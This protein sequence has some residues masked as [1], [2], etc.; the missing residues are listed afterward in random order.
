MKTEFFAIKHIA[1][2]SSTLDFINTGGT[3]YRVWLNSH[4]FLTL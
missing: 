4:N 1:K 3:A 2:I